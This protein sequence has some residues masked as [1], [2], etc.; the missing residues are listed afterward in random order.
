M[1]KD[2]AIPW[3]HHTFNP[4]WGCSRVSPGCLHCYAEAWARRCGLEVWGANGERR[5]ASEAYWRKPVA[6]NRAARAAGER[7][8][9]FC[10]SMCDVCERH[11]QLEVLQEQDATRRCLQELVLAT[12]HL[13]WLLLTKRPELFPRCFPA[14]FL[15]QPNVWPMTTVESDRQLRRVEA[16]RRV[17]SQILGLSLE[18]LLGPVDL[19]DHL[20]QHEGWPHN[21]G[22]QWVIVGCESRWKAPG[23]PMELAWARSLRDQCRAA[24]VAFYMKQLVIAGRVTSDL[25][26]FPE[27]LRVREYPA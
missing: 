22:V 21:R 13:D 10:G 12:P 27:D 17:D 1:G 24:G 4:W 7:H 19:D 15:A 25:T 26:L 8:R 16:L 20:Q 5:M 23:R 3:T 11:S 6:W 18:P 2:S 14:S 9:V